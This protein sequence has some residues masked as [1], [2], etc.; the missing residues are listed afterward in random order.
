MLQTIKKDFQR[1]KTEQNFQPILDNVFF[2]IKVKIFSIND[3]PIAKTFLIKTF[4][5]YYSKINEAKNR[6]WRLVF[7]LIKRIHNKD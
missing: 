6:F 5:K 1:L 4:S 7:T 3:L 2:L